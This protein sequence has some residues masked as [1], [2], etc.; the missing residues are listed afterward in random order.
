M[1]G[2]PK[3]ERVSTY[4]WSP[5]SNVRPRT[6]K[7]NASGV[8]S[9]SRVGVGVR[10]CSESAVVGLGEDENKVWVVEHW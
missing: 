5:P 3:G 1:T 8:C 4:I 10:Q 7:T 9:A 6:S 2:S